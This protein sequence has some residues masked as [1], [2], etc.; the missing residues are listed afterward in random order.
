M[1]KAISCEVEDAMLTATN[2]SQ[3]LLH[4]GAAAVLVGRTSYLVMT[5]CAK[6]FFTFHGKARWLPVPVLLYTYKIRT[7]CVPIHKY[8]YL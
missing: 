5:L 3:G 8:L 1:K 2:L 7:V 6:L 4:S